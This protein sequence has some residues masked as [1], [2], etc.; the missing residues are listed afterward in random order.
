M[1]LSLSPEVSAGPEVKPLERAWYPQTSL[2]RAAGARKWIPIEVSKASI[3]CISGTGPPEGG[4]SM[5]TAD[6]H[7]A[8][9]IVSTWAR[10]S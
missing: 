7:I 8:T 5:N 9:L 1:A 6:H 2:C 4:L 3:N 10:M